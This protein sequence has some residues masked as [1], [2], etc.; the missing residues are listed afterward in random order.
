MSKQSPTNTSIIAILND[1]LAGELAAINQYFLHAKMC[2]N[3]G[4]Q[5]LASKIRLESI[6]EMRHAEALIDRILFLEGLPN[7]QKLGKVTIGET[8]K[9]QF[10]VDR[11]LELEAIP[12][13]NQGIETCRLAGDNGTRLLLETILKAEEEHLDWLDTQIELIRQ[14]GLENYLAQQV[15][16]G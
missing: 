5:R 14:I 1:V 7:V 2:A 11:A 6:D 13:L 8:V 10:E 3:W 12:R 16:G 4:F 9:E 15:N